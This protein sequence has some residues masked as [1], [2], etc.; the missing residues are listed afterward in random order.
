MGIGNVMR[1]QHANARM[2]SILIESSH[3]RTRDFIPAVQNIADVNAI[4]KDIFET[5]AKQAD[6]DGVDMLTKF[7]ETDVVDAWVRYTGSFS[8]TRVVYDILNDLE[9]VPVFKNLANQIRSTTRKDPNVREWF[10]E[11][12]AVVKGQLTVVEPP[13]PPKK[14][15]WE[16]KVEGGITRY[17]HKDTGEESLGREVQKVNNQG[18]TYTAIEPPTTKSEG[19]T[20]PS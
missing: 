9:D 10:G 17:V 19:T 1:M 13:K 14:N 7:Y 20:T 15:P 8:N 12:P 4:M 5:I 2:E 3:I 6:L 16:K 18:E 11:Q